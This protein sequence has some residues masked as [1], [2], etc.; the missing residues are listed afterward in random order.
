MY[1]YIY[2]YICIYIY[3]YTYHTAS[4]PSDK[5]PDQDSGIGLAPFWNSLFEPLVAGRRTSQMRREPFKIAP[6]PQ[7]Y[8]LENKPDNRW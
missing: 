3:I 1:I 6:I 8:V 5:F 7:W 4:F 2:I